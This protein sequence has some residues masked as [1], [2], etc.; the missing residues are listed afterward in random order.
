MVKSITL[1]EKP[2][3]LK[4]VIST[5]YKEKIWIKVK[6]AERPNTYYTIRYGFVDGKE[7]FVVLMPQAPER[8]QIIIFNDSNGNIPQDTSFSIETRD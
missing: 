1:N 7:E 5:P 4:L 3:K 2:T 6:D 8:A